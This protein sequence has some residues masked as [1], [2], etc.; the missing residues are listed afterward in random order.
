MSN[1]KRDGNFIPVLQ[2]VDSDTFSIP[3]DV[4]VNPTTHALLIE[5]SISVDTTGLATAAN[6]TTLNGH[7]DGIETLLG[8]IDTDTGNISKS[9]IGP[10]S[11]AIDSYTHAAINLAAGAN[12]VLVSSAANKQIWVYGIGFTVNVAGTVSFQ[13]E[14]D[15]AITGVMSFSATSGMAIP[16][17]GN[18][19]MPIWKLGTDKDLEIDVVTSEIDGWIDYAI[20]S[21]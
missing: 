20:V 16:P 8:T 3:T 13:D 9:I 2:G 14:D 10:S 5:G 19:S 12:Q 11:P 21:V 7:V 6:Q 17:S 18:F 1:A 4:A 15:T